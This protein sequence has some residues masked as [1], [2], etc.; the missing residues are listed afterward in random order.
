MEIALHGMVECFQCIEDYPQF[1]LISCNSYNILF[2][3]EISCDHKQ[4]TTIPYHKTVSFKIFHKRNQLF[5]AFDIPVGKL[6]QNK[7]KNNKE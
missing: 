2:S 6:Q 3:T 1:I 7:T 4:G 5:A